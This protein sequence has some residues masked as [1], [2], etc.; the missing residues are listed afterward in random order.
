MTNERTL[1]DELERL[2][3]ALKAVK[4]RLA[5]AEAR[6]DLH[7][8]TQAERLDALRAQRGA[9]TSQ[10]DSLERARATQLE[11]LRTLEANLADARAS[12]PAHASQAQ[13]LE[14]SGMA[15]L[16]RFFMDPTPTWAR[17]RSW[18]GRIVAR[19]MSATGMTWK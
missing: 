10:L 14:N 12:I 19:L 2:G 16:L 5:T 8:R 4:Q 13:E 7:L 17:D 18:L 6:C 11:Q 3:A 15:S 1:R 9:L